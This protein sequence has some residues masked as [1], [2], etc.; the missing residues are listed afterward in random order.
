M[1]VS[2]LHLQEIREVE[3]SYPEALAEQMRIAA[4]I[5]ELR[6]DDVRLQALYQRKAVGISDLRKSILQKA[7]SGELTSPPWSAIK[8]AAE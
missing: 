8:E 3:I 2:N 5:D 4:E 6:T 7:F 1:G